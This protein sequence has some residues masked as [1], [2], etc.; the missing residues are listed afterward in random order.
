MIGVVDTLASVKSL[1]VILTIVLAALITVL[2][3]R[4]FIAKEQGGI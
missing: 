1:I 4:S 3:E 2:M